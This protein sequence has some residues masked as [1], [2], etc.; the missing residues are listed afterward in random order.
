MKR[1]NKRL[2]A[3]FASQHNTAVGFVVSSAR[4]LSSAS[5]QAA[6]HFVRSNPKMLLKGP[7][8]NSACD[9]SAGGPPLSPGLH[10]E[11]VMQDGIFGSFIRFLTWGFSLSTFAKV[12]RNR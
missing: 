5:L 1:C 11:M 7:P 4:Q 12:C 9:D 3:E 10:C 2:E 6:H 8:G